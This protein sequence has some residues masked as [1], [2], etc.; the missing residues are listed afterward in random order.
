[1]IARISSLPVLAL[2]LNELYDLL[3]LRKDRVVPKA[4]ERE[5]YNRARYTSYARDAKKAFG[6]FYGYLYKLV[7]PPYVSH[8]IA[9]IAWFADRV[10][11]VRVISRWTPRLRCGPWLLRLHIP[12]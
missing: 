10:A 2:A 4:G 8:L 11:E 9:R 12:S 7:T 1:M 3:I 6:E 5:P